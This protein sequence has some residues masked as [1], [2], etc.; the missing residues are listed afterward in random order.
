MTTCNAKACWDLLRILALCMA[1][2]AVFETQVADYASTTLWP[3]LGMQHYS[4]TALLAI[5]ETMALTVRCSR[6]LSACMHL[7]QV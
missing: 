2:I 7:S 4:D 5:A 6:Y 3:Q 1:D